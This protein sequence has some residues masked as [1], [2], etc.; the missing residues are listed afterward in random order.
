[1]ALNCGLSTIKYLLFVFNL[2]CSLC[3]IAL[4]VIG[5]VSLAQISELQSISEE[6]NVVAP[7]ILFI[8]L[9]SV[10]FII[11][12]FGCCGA[13][14]ESYCMTS[15]YGFFLLVLIIGQ[16][17][18]AALIFVYVGDAGEAF[19]RGFGKIF[20]E[21]NS[22]Q[23]NME[24]VET[25]QR[26]LQC[27]GRTSALDWGLKIPDSCCNTD[28]PGCIPYITGC[29]KRLGEFINKVGDVLGWVSLGVAAVELVGLIAA[30]C[31]ANGI[32]NQKRR[33]A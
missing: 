15:T 25:V 16:I 10:V 27:C 14:R 13:L 30:C 31:L 18:I 17:V 29:E 22:N 6:H 24:L 4:I 12:F 3:G 28:L 20:D 33:Y 32:R 9:G 11:S 21:R 5:G 1:M 8:V 26:N 19:V 2:L 23:A 7:A